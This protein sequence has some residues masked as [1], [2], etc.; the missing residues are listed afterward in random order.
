MSQPLR[1][2]FV[3]DGN[4]ARSQMAAGL[5]RH[6]GGS[7]FEVYSAALE[8]AAPQPQAIAAMQEIG[9]DIAGQPTPHIDEYEALQFDYVIS[10]C[11]EAKESCLAFPRDR[12]NLHW[13]CDAPDPAA[14]FRLVRDQLRRQI[15]QW[16]PTVRCA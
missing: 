11:E 10:L 4:A 8:A 14:A 1:V 2:L 6:L 12:E 16:L 5:L 9:I 3:C 15:E 13:Q 7:A